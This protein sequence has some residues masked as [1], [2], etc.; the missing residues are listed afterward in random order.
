MQK[1][2]ECVINEIVEAAKQNNEISSFGKDV[3][4]ILLKHDLIE[5][6]VSEILIDKQLIKEKV[7][8]K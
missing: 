1:D 5:Q 2:L 3:V 8:E 7:N 6:A 4:N